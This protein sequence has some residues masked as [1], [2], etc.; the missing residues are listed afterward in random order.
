M[1]EK[2]SRDETF[3]QFLPGPGKNPPRWA[4]GWGKDVGEFRVVMY[5]PNGFDH[6]FQ[7]T[8]QGGSL[9][10]RFREHGP[11]HIHVIHLQSGRESSF[12]LVQG[13]SAAENSVRL[14][15]KSNENDRPRYGNPPPKPLT[16]AQVAKITPQLAPLV[17]GFIQMWQEAYCDHNM[18][19]QVRRQSHIAPNCTTQQIFYADGSHFVDVMDMYSNLVAR[20]RFEDYVAHEKDSSK[21]KRR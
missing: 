18:S 17:G 8:L 12:E 1:A 20:L 3:V 13:V 21:G 6:S 10:P 9:R 2:P 4:F 7:F 5:A 15:A 19:A 16:E 14:M 11:A